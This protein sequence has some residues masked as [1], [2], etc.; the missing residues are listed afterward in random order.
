MTL[1][2]EKSLEK[3]LELVKQFDNT[4]KRELGDSDE[5]TFNKND[6][7]TFKDALEMDL[8]MILNSSNFNETLNH[9]K[10]GI[11]SDTQFES[12]LSLED[13]KF[14]LN[15]KKNNLEKSFKKPLKT[16]INELEGKL[17]FMSAIYEEDRKVACQ[18][19]AELVNEFDD[20]FAV[21]L[22]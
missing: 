7:E 17:Y 14:K 19:C 15:A 4:V 20:C 18:K 3:K 21:Y 22:K 12:R 10:G 11:L 5:L 16:E 8:K 13:K 9:V 2:A 1:D 6:L